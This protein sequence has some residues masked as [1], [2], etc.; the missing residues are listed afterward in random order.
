MENE[1]LMAALEVFIHE[2]TADYLTSDS[3]N[4]SS[5]S[6]Q[7]MVD[8]SSEIRIWTPEQHLKTIKDKLAGKNPTDQIKNDLKGSFYSWYVCSK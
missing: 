7:E 8:S 5:S 3:F 6:N 1:S 4:R 2:P